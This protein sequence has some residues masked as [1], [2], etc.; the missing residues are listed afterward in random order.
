M[1][2]E[3]LIDKLEQT[4]LAAE[5]GEFQEYGEGYPAKLIL[6]LVLEYVGNKKIQEKVDE[7]PF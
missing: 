1:K 4:R 3:S 7:I 2:I 5:N 6:Q